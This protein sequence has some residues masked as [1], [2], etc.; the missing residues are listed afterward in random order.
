MTPED[1]GGAAPDSLP[2]GTITLLFSDIEGSTVL[3]QQLGPQWAE[4]LTAQ[5]SILRD[6]F[7]AQGG[8]EMGTE[9]DSFF[10]VFSSAHAALTAALEGQRR[11]QAH[12][13][14]GGLPVRVRMGLHTGEPQRH[15]DGYIGID[16]HRAARIAA[17]AN[18]G[19]VVLSEPTKLL[20]GTTPDG[21]QVRDL[22]WHRLKDLEGLN[23]LFDAV[24]VCAEGLPT[25]PPLRTLGTLANLPTPWT[26]LIGRGEDVSRLASM[27][28]RDGARLVTLTGPGGTGKTRLA[29]AVASALSD[30]FPHGIFFVELHTADRGAMMWVGI[31]EAVGATGE[32][33]EQPRERVLRFL[34]DRRA[35][36]VLDNVEQIA[37][38]DEVIDQLLVHAPEVCVLATS[39]R[40]MHLVSEFEYPVPPLELPS[41][42]MSSPDNVQRSGAVELFV[43]RA[44]MAHPHFELTAEN[45]RDV[46]E[47][48]TKLDG[49]P[50]AIELAAAR[51]RLL[52]PRAMV[53][54]INERLGLGVSASDRAPRQRSLG[55]TIAWSYDLLDEVDQRVFRRLGV[56]STSSDLAAV[57][58]VAAFDVPDFFDVVARLVDASLVKVVD[59]TDAE[60]RVSMLETIRSF[61]RDRVEA[62][63]EGEDARLRHARWCLA[64]ATEVVELLRGP[65]Q[66]SALDRMDLVE[67]DIRS[68]LDWCLRPTDGL[69]HRV[70]TGFDILAVMTTYWYRFGYVAEGRGWFERALRVA[71]GV[72]SAGMVDVL[73]GIGIMMSQQSDLAPAIEAFGRALDLARR[74]DDR[75]RE[76]RE[77]NSLGITHREAGDLT[78]ARTLIDDSLRLAIQMGNDQREATALT[79]MVMVLIDSGD[80]EG[81]VQMAYRAT[82]VDEARGDPWGVAIN[83]ANLTMALLRAEGPR[84]AYDH[85]AGVATQIL[86]LKDVELSI[87]VVELFAA[88]LAELG[89]CQ[90]AAPLMGTADR[91]REKVGLPRSDPDTA[92]LERSL[93]RARQAMSPVEW[94]EAHQVGKTISVEEAVGAALAAVV[95][96]AQG[97]C[98]VTESRGAG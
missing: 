78:S 35:L 97:R 18:G 43:R 16:V 45:V 8:H 55:D 67:E 75:G 54:R 19:Q 89:D 38:A 1:G 2:A 74:L 30:R 33:D 13:W 7:A 22:G 83:N 17:T 20:I 81:A 96:S 73:H 23:H 64:A 3:L 68:A 49:L 27:F 29:V 61:A 58:L 53:K 10:V 92:H 69:D 12:P 59:S 77:L 57:E 4:A 86:A 56:F 41:R 60:P 14:P 25:F 37:D 79:N 36:L 51:S 88:A 48:C 91:Q 93:E 9:G 65:T 63:D 24:E 70:E 84:R 11:L 76:S 66:M 42:G 95:S 5:R 71:G 31:G 34:G 46:A 44:R 6:C 94:D 62:T 28:E 26:A 32:A 85:L 40:T 15:E 87:V 72:E 21:V 98:D 52:S 50:L 39:R 82:T 47:L 90:R 80:F